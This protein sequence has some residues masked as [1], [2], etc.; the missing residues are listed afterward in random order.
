MK[1][2]IKTLAVI[3]LSACFF[4][5]NAQSSLKQNLAVISIETKNLTI[6]PLAMGNITRTELEKLDSFNVIDKYEI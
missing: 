5:S 3:L 4:G 1:T 6:D 2:T